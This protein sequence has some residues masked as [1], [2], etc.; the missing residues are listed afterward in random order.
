MPLFQ[1]FMAMASVSLFFSP[2]VKPISKK[3]NQIIMDDS[4]NQIPYNSEE[5]YPNVIGTNN[6][7]M[8]ILHPF[9]ASEPIMFFLTAT[10]RWFP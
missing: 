10:E 1:S 5:T 7:D 3:F 4:V 6:K 8:I 9:I 2:N